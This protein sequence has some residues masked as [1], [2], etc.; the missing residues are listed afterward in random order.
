VHELIGSYV[1]DW[2]D[3]QDGWTFSEALTAM[4]C[5]PENEETQRFCCER[6]ISEPFSQ[7]MHLRGERWL[8]YPIV[9]DKRTND[10]LLRALVCH[11]TSLVVPPVVCQAM[12]KVSSGDGPFRG[13]GL[14]LHFM[15]L[16][17]QTA[18]QEAYFRSLTYLCGETCRQGMIAEG[19]PL[20]VLNLRKHA[21]NAQ[22]LF[23]TKDIIQ[24]LTTAGA[25]VLSSIS[26]FVFRFCSIF[27]CLCS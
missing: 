3:L 26:N 18:V 15:R 27:C 11:Q 13:L 8:I 10:L 20:I 19:I 17:D 12:S 22:L 5:Y 9:V 24:Q 16:S 4:N 6:L 14:L 23:Y 7:G 1:C 21:H 25:S 2:P